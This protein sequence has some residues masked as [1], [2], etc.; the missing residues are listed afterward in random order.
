M[1]RLPLPLWI[2]LSEQRKRS[3]L[4][5]CSERKHRNV[6]LFTA[7][8]NLV[9]NHIVHIV[10]SFRVNF[11]FSCSERQ[12]YCR[13]I[14]AR[15]GRM[16]L[17]DNHGKSFIFQPFDRIDDIGEFLNGRNDN[18]R[19][20]LQ[21]YG[22]VGGRTFI[23]HNANKPRLVFHT[24][25][26]RL[27][28]PVHY[29]SVGYYKDIIED[30]FVVLVVQGCQP[31]RKPSNG[32]SFARTRTVLNQ[33]VLRSSVCAHVGEQ[34]ADYVQ[35]VISGEYYRLFYRS[36]ARNLVHFLLAFDKDKLGDKVKHGILFE[37]ILP[38]IP[39]RILIFIYGVSLACIY[40]FAVAHIEGQKE[41]CIAR[42]FCRHIYFFKVHRK[43]YKAARLKQ[44]QT[45]FGV[46]LLAELINCVLIRLSR[47]VAFELE[48]YYSNAVQK[49]Y[50]VNAL[51]VARPHLFHYRENITFVFCD[52]LFVVCSGGLCV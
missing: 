40:A 46:A 49:Y 23:V 47:N 31:V 10:G 13:H 44:E 3:G 51:F 35:L 33:I 11:K 36:S 22:K 6:G 30:N 1:E 17:I 38:H 39:D 7:T 26:C 8:R 41:C 4:W 27:Q 5:R 25:Y 9:D 29:N 16:R 45:G 28:L 34:L 48:R 37:D 52:E 12:R 18:F 2:D 50:E 43:I 24:C 42:K 14:F 19:V 21:C 15:S 20:A 32:I